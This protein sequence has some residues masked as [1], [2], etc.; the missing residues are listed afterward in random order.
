M[1][2]LFTYK[3]KELYA[4]PDEIRIKDLNIWATFREYGTITFTLCNNTL[5]LLYKKN[6]KV[7]N[8]ED[9]I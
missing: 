9:Y 2:Q 8:Y 7:I 5:Y 6:G 1:V 4:S 3:K